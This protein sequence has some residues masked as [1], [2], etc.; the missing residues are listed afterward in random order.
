MSVAD[1]GHSFRYGYGL[2][3]INELEVCTEQ[4]EGASYGDFRAISTP[5]LDDPT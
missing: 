5:R 2:G 4:K 3:L 1:R